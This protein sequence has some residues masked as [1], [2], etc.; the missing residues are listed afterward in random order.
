MPVNINYNS[1]GRVNTLFSA[2]NNVGVTYRKFPSIYSKIGITGNNPSNYPSL[3]YKQ[4]RYNVSIYHFTDGF[5]HITTPNANS[6]NTPPELWGRCQ[7]FYNCGVP[8]ENF[9]FLNI[10]HGQTG[11]V[12]VG[13]DTSPNCQIAASKRYFAYAYGTENGLLFIIKSLSVFTNNPQFFMVPPQQTILLLII[14]GIQLVF[15]MIL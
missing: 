15:L 12:C 13:Y 11:G 9:R 7:N 3:R 4:N 14:W 8:S 6:P 2:E 10:T 1:I 5:V